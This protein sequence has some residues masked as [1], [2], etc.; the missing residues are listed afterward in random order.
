[1]SLPLGKAVPVWLLLMLGILISLFTADHVRRNLIKDESFRVAFA[2]DQIKMKLRNRL[3]AHELSLRGAAGLFATHDNVD[4]AQWKAYVE[5]LQMDEIVPGTQGIGYAELIQPEQLETHI[6]RIRREGFPKYDVNPS[7]KRELHSAII[8]L[9]PFRDRN[10]RAFGYDMY[11]EPIRRAAM[12][13]A[14]DTGKAALSGAVQLV[15]ETDKEAQAGI[16]MYMPVYRQGMAVDTVEQRQSALMGW[17]YSPF[18]M[19]DLIINAL[20]EWKGQLGSELSLSLFDVVEQ[21]P[22]RPLFSASGKRIN[23]T[24]HPALEH[25]IIDF[26]GNQWLLAVDHAHGPFGVDYIAAWLTL[27]GGLLLSSMLATLVWSLINTRANAIRIAETLTADIKQREQQLI[28]S[29]YRWKF[30]LEGSDLGVWDWDIPGEKLFYSKRWKEMLGHTENEI[31]NGQAEW[32]ERIHPDDLGETMTKLQTYFEGK[33]PLYQHEHRI[34]C[35]DGSYKWILDRGMVVSRGEDGK[36]L[37]MIGTYADI[38]ERIAVIQKQLESQAQLEQAQRIAH[39]GSWQLELATG[40]IT[41][42]SELSRIYGLDPENPPPG[43]D[44]H[45]K[46]LTDESWKRL[47]VA[48]AQTQN[49]GLPYEIE[50]EVIKAN[51]EH[52]WILARGEAKRGVDGLITSIQGTALDITQHKR[53][54]QALIDSQRL[55]RSVIE[56]APVRIFWKDTE[57]RYLGCNY[58]FAQDAGMAQP[59]DLYGKDDF[60]LSWH[61]S[62][63]LYRADDMQVIN[64][65]IPKLGFEESIIRADGSTIWLRT[66]KVP[67]H[68][69]NGKISGVLGTYEDISEDKLYEINILRLTNLYAAL[70]E[71]NSAVIH[72][73]SED[74]L[75]KRLCEIVVDLC[76]VA[77]AWVGQTNPSGQIIPVASHGCHL[78]YLDN[79]TVTIDASEPHGRGPTVIAARE[80]HSIWI[81]DFR[82]STITTPWQHCASPYGWI[83]SAALPIRRNGKLVSVLSLYSKQTGG[84]ENEQTRNQFEKMVSTI[85]LALEKFASAEEALSSQA[86]LLESEQ[87]FRTMVEQSI[88]GTFIIQNDAFIYVNPRLEQILGYPVGDGLVGQSP[89]S[90][91]ADKDRNMAAQQLRRLIDGD[92]QNTQCTFTAIRRDGSHTEVGVNMAKAQ[93][94]QQPA[95]IGLMQDISDRKVAE[96]QISRYAKQLEHSFM[97]MVTLATTLSEMR[98]AYTAGHEKR[99]ALIAVAIGREMGLDAGR[100][101]GLEVGGHLHDVGKVSIPSEYLSKPGRLSPIEYEVIKFHAQAGYDVLKNIDFPW[102]VAQIAHQ[103]HERLDGSGYPQG[104]KGDQIIL[105]ARIVAVADVVESMGSHRPYRAALGIDKALAEIERG[106]GSLYDPEVA[107][108]CLRLFREKQ[109]QLPT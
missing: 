11:S 1:M 98:D 66:S 108:V 105:E 12:E 48:L 49:D 75:Y 74:E 47:N 6:S 88:A 39:L 72:C 5:L 97:Q 93:F 89:L 32:S 7:G 2:A 29:E 63:E 42:S 77:M 99:V 9:E 19:N 17:A 83:S 70:S 26:N 50:L 56:N 79:I 68:D 104:L 95:L 23:H 55:I 43:L 38:T 82:N 37:R 58:V 51:G 90:I 100:L 78:E 18:R 34:L 80:N 22:A 73:K 92:G 57:L 27:L 45:R 87:R 102:P 20:S 46:M 16:L 86:T 21:T 84:W 40:H 30:S 14:R 15:Q 13:Q 54:S 60:Q 24:D 35:K 67:L 25:R 28:E 62:A 33:L 65:G 31:G 53:A 71:C 91:V 107:A 41:W 76:G 64:S 69:Q 96:E 106:S 8:Y 59:E 4:R 36:P 3:L 52:S 101:E 44:Q 10:L 61:G 103:H 109:Y 81:N 94:Q 85:G